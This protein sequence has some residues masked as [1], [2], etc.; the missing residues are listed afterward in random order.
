MNRRAEELGPT[1]ETE[2]LILRPPVAEDFAGFCT[3]LGDSEATR[4]IGGVQSPAIVWR[5]LRSVAGGWALDGFHF[6]S[7]I[8]KSSGAWIGRIGPI[9]PHDWPGPEV[10]WGL[11][12]AYWGKGY[13]TEAASAAMDFV[14]DRLGWERVIHTIAPENEASAAVARALG[15]RH[16]GPGKLPEP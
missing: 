13:A 7:V 9:Y 4:F 10:G 14:F 15:S 3:F 8:E 11:L 2:R 16:I 5:N 12:P 1:L 6:F